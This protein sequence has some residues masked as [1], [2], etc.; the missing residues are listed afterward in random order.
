MIHRA[1][2][3][4]ELCRSYVDGTVSSIKGNGGVTYTVV[5]VRPVHLSDPS[6]SS[7]AASEQDHT[8]TTTTAWAF[9]K[10]ASAAHE[11]EIRIT[12]SSDF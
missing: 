3:Y 1:V 12:I 10:M 8:I 11:N 2:L 7:A 6:I 5:K 4:S 9:D